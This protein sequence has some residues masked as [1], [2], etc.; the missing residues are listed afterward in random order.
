MSLDDIH[1]THWWEFQALLS[2][3]P[4]D[5]RLSQIMRIRSMDI[6]PKASPAEKLK[7]QRAKTLVRIKRKRRSGETGFDVIS[8][9]LIEGDRL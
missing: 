2:G 9:G 4:E 3:L 5:T 7:I 8:R 1:R 6:D